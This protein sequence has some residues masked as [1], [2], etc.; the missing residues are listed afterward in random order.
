MPADG[1]IAARPGT[2]RLRPVPL[3][4]S[5]VQAR[6]CQPPEEGVSSSMKDT[7]SVVGQTRSSGYF[8]CMS[9]QAPQAEIQA[10]AGDVRLVP[11]VLQKFPKRRARRKVGPFRD[12]AIYA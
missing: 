9:A 6:R 10:P 12:P 5:F 4:G 1:K 2:E 8:R 7:M 3:H 11:I